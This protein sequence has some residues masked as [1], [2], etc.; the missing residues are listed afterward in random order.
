[1]IRGRGAAADEAI[2]GGGLGGGGERGGGDGGV[3]LATGHQQP[4]LM[5]LT[6]PYPSIRKTYPVPFFLQGTMTQH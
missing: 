3:S 4:L 1:M 5:T 6:P 2:K